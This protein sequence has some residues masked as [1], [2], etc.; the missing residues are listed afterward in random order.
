MRLRS[1]HAS[2]W[3]LFVATA[4]RDERGWLAETLR[5]DVLRAH[6]G[7]VAIAQQNLSRSRRGVLRGLHYQL[8]PPQGKLVQ[9]IEGRVFDVI[10]D[11]RRASPEFGAS[12]AFELC[13]D[14]PQ[15][16]WIPPGFAHGFL[17]REDSLVLYGLTQPWSPLH[18][19]AIRWNSPGL[20]IDWPLAGMQ[21]ILSAR[22]RDA[23]T[24]GEAEP[25]EPDADATSGPDGDIGVPEAAEAATTARGARR[26]ADRGTARG[27]P[28]AS[29]R[30]DR[31]T[32]ERR[33]HDDRRTPA[34]GRTPR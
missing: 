3:A 28:A 23:P 17:A 7:P 4:H 9:V 22:D 5:T 24:F 10:V 33:V 25:F 30:D 19:R 32:A 26:A 11:L 15:M 14:E 13:A 2:G 27:D 29:V 18:E 6:A 16:L 21:P 12:F 1:A 8:G 34:K 31:D 20:T